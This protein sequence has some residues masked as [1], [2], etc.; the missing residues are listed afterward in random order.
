MRQ[1]FIG[2]TRKPAL[3]RLQVRECVGKGALILD[4]AP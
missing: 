1:S 3:V 4:I 2:K